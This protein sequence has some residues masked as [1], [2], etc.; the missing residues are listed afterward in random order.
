MTD[1]NMN[2]LDHLEELRKR[3]L[4][5]FTAFLL[6]F[7]SIFVFIRD[8]YSW[9]TRGLDMPLAVL[10]PLDIVVIYFSLA[11]VIAFALTV[12]VVVFQIWLFVK[13]ALTAKE[14]KVTALYIPAS[15]LLF[16]G[17]LAFGYFVVMPLVLNFLLELGTGT[18][19]IMLTADKYFQFVLRMTV[20]FSILFEM[21]L[22]VMFLTSV[23]MMTPMAMK[24]NR[25]YAYF[26]IVVVSVV[27]SPPDFISDV[28][29]IIPLILLYEISINLSAII[30]RRRLKREQLKERQEIVK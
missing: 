18:F 23:G 21:P 22:V 1:K 17:G 8:I 11:A 10:G 12:P 30:Y 20:P 5:V 24:K 27:I 19:E 16:I 9:F 14:K 15:F 6:I 2:V 29:V 25:K 3:I 28:L 4:I 7:I 26:A 13:P